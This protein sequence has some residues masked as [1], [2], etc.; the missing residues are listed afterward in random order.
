[1][2]GRAPGRALPSPAFACVRLL[3]RYD[4][5]LS[6]LEIYNE[7]IQA[8]RDANKQAAELPGCL[9]DLL[10]DPETGPRE[11]LQEGPCPSPGD[12]QTSP[13]RLRAALR[14]ALQLRAGSLRGERLE[15]RQSR[16]APSRICL[17][18]QLS[19]HGCNLHL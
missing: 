6:A 17:N 9:E 12:F 1:M 8:K 5:R 15:V 7:S 18:S 10:G 19:R 11:G 16:E 2:Q 13:R 3:A 4:V 14:A